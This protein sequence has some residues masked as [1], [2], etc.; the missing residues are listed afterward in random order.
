MVDAGKAERDAELRR[1]F[2]E[3]ECEGNTISTPADSHDHVIARGKECLLVN[4]P[5]NC[6]QHVTA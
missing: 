6:L 3:D 2:G 1:E 5:P 4:V